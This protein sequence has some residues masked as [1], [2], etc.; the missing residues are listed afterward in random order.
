MLRHLRRNLVA[1][2][3]LFVALGGTSYAAIKL[4]KNSVGEKQIKKNAVTGT[5]IKNGSVTASKIKNGSAT[6]SKIGSN[7]IT[8]PKVQDGSLTRAD[9]RSGEVPN[10]FN[11]TLPSGSSLRGTWSASGAGVAS[12]PP[13]VGAVSF[14]V[15]LG[16]APNPHFVFDGDTASTSCPGNAAAPSAARGQLCVY[17]SGG[18]DNVGS[19]I[20]RAPGS[21][22]DPTASPFGTVVVVSPDT[23]GPIQ[24]S[25]SWAVTA[26]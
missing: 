4:P 18:F 1:Y 20:L 15:V 12:G 10:A 26:P 11:G 5:K 9:F 13:A 7:S 25:G 2:L 8:S 17:Q 21:N 14:G 3:A 16:S 23:D 6:S 24:S 19:I 22:D